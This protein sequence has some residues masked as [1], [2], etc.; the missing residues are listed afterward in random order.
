MPNETC[1]NGPGGC[2]NLPNNFD[3][4]DFDA[5]SHLWMAVLAKAVDDALITLPLPGSSSYKELHGIKSGA[6]L[7]IKSIDERVGSMVWI[8]V[9]LGIEPEDIRE[10]Y[11]KRSR[12]GSGA[13]D[14]VGRRGP[15]ARH[16]PANPRN[17][18]QPQRHESPTPDLLPERR[19]DAA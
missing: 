14:Q 2:G 1:G 5:H 4:S 6:T 16:A 12:Q 8:C 11:D 18:V 17:E 19:A 3:L 9:Q 15:S 7:W 13:G 10:Q